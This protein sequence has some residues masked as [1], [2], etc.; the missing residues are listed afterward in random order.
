MYFGRHHPG[1]TAA[2]T[3]MKKIVVFSPFGLGVLDLAVAHH[4]H[5]LAF[6][7]NVGMV[8]NSFLPDSNDDRE[9]VAAHVEV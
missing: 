9:T 7:N 5:E 1:E 2:R 8:I 6:R 4:V 3:S